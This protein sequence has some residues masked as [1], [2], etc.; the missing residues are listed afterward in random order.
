MRRRPF[1]NFE[2]H[3]I[4][5]ADAVADGI[6]GALVDRQPDLRAPLA[7]KQAALEQIL[8]EVAA[9]FEVVPLREAAA[10]LPV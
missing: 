4:D 2:L 3:G 10:R 8:D 1:F 7:R 9:R 6:P 5:L